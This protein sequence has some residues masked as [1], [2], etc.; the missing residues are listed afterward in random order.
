MW[1]LTQ[2]ETAFVVELDR[3]KEGERKLGCNIKKRYFHTK[4]EKKKYCRFLLYSKHLLIH[5][6]QYI[7]YS[8]TVNSSVI[9]IKKVE[10]K[11]RGF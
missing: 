4:I 9:K 11:S 10:T 6:Q 7:L 5:I 2:T 1:Y 8:I 3:K